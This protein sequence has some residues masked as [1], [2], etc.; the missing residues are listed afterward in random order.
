MAR[1][2]RNHC[3]RTERRLD[4]WAAAN[5]PVTPSPN[6]L[7]QWACVGEGS[8]IMSRIQEA[9]RPLVVPGVGRIDLMPASIRSGAGPRGLEQ[10]RRASRFAHAPA[11]KREG[12]PSGGGSP[13]GNSQRRPA[14]FA[15]VDTRPVRTET[16]RRR[17]GLN[18]RS[19][20]VDPSS[21]ASRAPENTRSGPTALR[22]RWPHVPAPVGDRRG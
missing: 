17:V 18:E 12:N 7:L 2:P 15:D 19:V 13:T 4:V 11:K 14:L 20:G 3:G 9:A 10:G 8:R 21:P 16:H 22:R 5:D 6:L 1:S